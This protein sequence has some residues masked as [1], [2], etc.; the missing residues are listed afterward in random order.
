MPYVEE[1]EFTFRL[2]LKRGF[3][4]QYQGEEDGYAWAAD[5]APL[6]GEMMQALVAVA[7]RHGWKV[8]PRNRGRSTDDE[9]TLVLEKP[10]A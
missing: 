2:E 3:G 4:E 6:A 7:Q 1:R 5:V 9:V 10:M 8:H